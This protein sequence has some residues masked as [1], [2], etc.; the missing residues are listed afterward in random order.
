MDSWVVPAFVIVAAA[1]IVLQA[2]IL[3]AMYLQFRQMN[4]RMTHIATDL[5]AKL[6]PILSRLRFLVDDSHG[7]IVS[8]ATD[9]AEIAQL[10]RGQAQKVDRVFTEAVDRLRLQIIRADQ[11]LTGALE[12]IEEAGSK[13]R[14]S[15]SGPVEEVAA[16]VKGVKTGLEF[17]RGRR[18][19]PER[20]RE[21]QDEELFI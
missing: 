12:H 6:D 3:G 8:M 17:F 11:I 10:A 14:K 2:L 18:R 16:F 4:E 7:R 15:V 20:A 1:A 5:H 19:S 13:L 21:R 9:A